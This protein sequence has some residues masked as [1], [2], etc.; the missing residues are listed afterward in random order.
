MEKENSIFD[1]FSIRKC[2]LNIPKLQLVLLRLYRIQ[3]LVNLLKAIVC[4]F[5]GLWVVFCNS[6]LLSISRTQSIQSNWSPKYSRFDCLLTIQQ[7]RGINSSYV[8]S[9]LARTPKREWL[10]AVLQFNPTTRP[11]ISMTNMSRI[12]TFLQ[13]LTSQI[14]IKYCF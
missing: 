5:V 10:A 1:Y 11:S 12:V 8:Q 7:T 3:L 9:P 6:W 4:R 13:S 14:N 2:S